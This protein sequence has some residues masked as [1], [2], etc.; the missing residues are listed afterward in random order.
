VSIKRREGKLREG[1]ED[2]RKV[3]IE[4][5]VAVMDENRL[6]CGMPRS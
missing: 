4:V 3:E 6:R 2:K 5:I 1:V